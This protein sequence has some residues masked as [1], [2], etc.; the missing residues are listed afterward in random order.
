[1]KNKLDMIVCPLVLA[2]A[3]LMPLEA[4]P[5]LGTNWV[6]NGN[7]EAGAGSADGSVVPVP[8]WTQNGAIPL[9]TAVQYQ[10]SPGG[11]PTTTDPGPAD[12]GAN[13]FAGGPNV[14][15][16]MGVQDLDVS[17]LAGQI[18]AGAVTFVMSAY[19]GGFSTQIDYT[20]FHVLYLDAGNNQ[21]NFNGLTGPTVADRSNATGLL[22]VSTSG[23]IPVGTRTLEFQLEM[24]RQEG[25]YD[26]GYADDLSFVA[27][28]SAAPPAPPAGVPEPASLL[29]LGAGGLA[30]A[31]LGRKRRRN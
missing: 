31:A 1:M 25:S 4:G 9:F 21:L 28:S 14:G 12:R 5:I 19:L 26:D 11:F 6:V 7:A 24:T 18:D 2:A 16:A 8:S 17:S 13:F 30:L 10:I 15:D 3:A 27:S 23:T 29:L 20:T 22:F